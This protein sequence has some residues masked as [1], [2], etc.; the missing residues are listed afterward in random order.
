[1]AE[2]ILVGIALPVPDPWR[3]LLGSV[4]CALGDPLGEVV[5][6]H[7]TVLPPTWVRP[8]QLPGL[9]RHA[10]SVAAAWAPI[11]VE[12]D[13]VETFLPDSD[14]VYARLTSGADEC[15]GLAA[16]LGSG[17]VT[18]RPTYPFHAHVTIAHHC[19]PAALKRALVLLSGFRARFDLAELLV[20][21]SAGSLTE[22]TAVQRISFNPAPIATALSAGWSR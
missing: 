22:W 1:M 4:R 6:A 13:G 18:V 19:G 5:P 20:S 8:A 21:I 7:V 2:Q 17:P 9:V 3:A 10:R 14:V 11:T 15:A 16:G 12:L